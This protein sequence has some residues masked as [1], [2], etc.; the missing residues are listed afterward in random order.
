MEPSARFEL[1]ANRLQGGCA[2]Y[3][4]SRALKVDDANV[5]GV[6]RKFGRAD[7][8]R[9]C[10]RCFK[11]IRPAAERPLYG[12]R[13]VSGSV[14]RSRRSRPGC[15]ITRVRRALRR[16]AADTAGKP[17]FCSLCR[18]LALGGGVRGT[19]PGLTTGPR[20]Y[21]CASGFDWEGGVHP[22]R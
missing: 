7:R 12:C 14:T 11:G 8:I 6:W 10:V 21:L 2:T 1:A 3:G 15:S 16:P 22:L 13:P 17:C 20:A 19:E 5:A 4:A 18:P 9:T